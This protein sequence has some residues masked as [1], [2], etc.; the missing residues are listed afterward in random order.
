MK[1][2][3]IGILPK[4]NL[5]TNDNPYEDYYQFVDLYS[6]KIIECGAIP[7][8]ILLNNGK[9]DISSLEICDAFLLPGGK[10][11]ESC[12]YET[13]Y[14]AITHNKPVLGVCLGMQAIAIFSLI[15][16]RLKEEEKKDLSFDRFYEIYR[17][18]KAENEDAILNK[19]P[20]QNIH[21]HE[22]NREN[23]D[24]A[25]HNIIIKD[26]TQ[27]KNIYN[28]NEISVVSLHSMYVPRI[29]SDFIISAYST[30]GIIEAIE[31][32]EKFIVGVQFHPEIEEDNKLFNKFIE[33]AK[34]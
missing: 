25:R 23:K 6:K 24:S 4:L 8:G 33:S 16:E 5:N 27:L 32:K 1:K 15:W 18:L 30:D 7:V 17:E 22:I 26:S 14:Y 10:K 20:E 31:H 28:S 3:V 19:L 13:L 2:V 9:L 12:M 11:I 34:N 29:G 21:T